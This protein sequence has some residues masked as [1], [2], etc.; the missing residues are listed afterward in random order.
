M[1]ETLKLGVTAAP[2]RGKANR[3]ACALLA[4]ALG[5]A[6]ERI[7]LV[8]GSG[9]TRKWVEI[10][11]LEMTQIQQRLEKKNLGTKRRPL[12]AHDEIRRRVKFLAPGR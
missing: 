12:G 1:G 6:K 10:V 7:R 3:A 2:E 5:I 4:E 11:G 9:T 8:T